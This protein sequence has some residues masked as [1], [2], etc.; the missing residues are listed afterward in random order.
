[1]G[2]YFR[3]EKAKVERKRVADASKGM[4]KPKVGGPFALVDQDGRDWESGVE[5]GGRFSLVSFL[6]ACIGWWGYVSRRRCSDGV[7]KHTDMNLEIKDNA[8]LHGTNRRLK[9]KDPNAN[10]YG[11]CI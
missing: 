5:M 3:S 8:V 6:R 1:M 11:L 2:F 10:T 4:G 9:T 7:L